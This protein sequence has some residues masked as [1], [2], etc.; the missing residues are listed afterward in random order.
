M[1]SKGH[2]FILPFAFFLVTVKVEPTAHF[3]YFQLV[4][5]L[6]FGCFGL[7]SI[8]SSELR[9]SEMDPILVWAQLAQPQLAPLALE[10]FNADTAST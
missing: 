1:F 5:I 3:D 8:H 6:D 10:S 4:I 2:L 7:G 9:S